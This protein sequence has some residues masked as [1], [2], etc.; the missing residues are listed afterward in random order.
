M[1]HVHRYP[2][3]TVG[4]VFLCNT[5][6]MTLVSAFAGALGNRAGRWRL[7]AAGLVRREHG[8]STGSYLPALI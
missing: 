1:E 6:A 3:S 5:G 2:P 7:I 4:L 8:L